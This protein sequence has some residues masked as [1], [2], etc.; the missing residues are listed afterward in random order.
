MNLQIAISGQEL[1]NILASLLLLSPSSALSSSSPFIFLI[2]LCKP[3]GAVQWPVIFPN[4]LHLGNVRC[5]HSASLS[6]PSPS[7]PL[8]PRLLC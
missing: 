6:L 1:C 2:L 5:P 7:V 3:C 8:L 4:F